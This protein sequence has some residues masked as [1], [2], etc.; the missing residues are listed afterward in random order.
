MPTAIDKAIHTP[1]TTVLAD[2][3]K[4]PLAQPQRKLL[5]R[6]SDIAKAMAG[7]P[8]SLRLT[9]RGPTLGLNNA[10][11]Q[12]GEF[13]AWAI[14]DLIQAKFRQAILGQA[15]GVTEEGACRPSALGAQKNLS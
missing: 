9:S 2:Y 6:I 13:A 1:K 10:H 3:R 14:A 5:V 4:Q 12:F 8:E 15:T 7:R 11:S